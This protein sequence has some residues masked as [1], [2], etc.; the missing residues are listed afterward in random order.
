MNHINFFSCEEVDIIVD[1]S[2]EVLKKYSCAHFEKCPASVGLSVENLWLLNKNRSSR[3][4][5]A[6]LKFGLVWVHFQ[7]PNL[8]IL[9][10][11]TFKSSTN[12]NNVYKGL[13]LALPNVSLILMQ[14]TTSSLYISKTFSVEDVS[15]ILLSTCFQ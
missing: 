6:K 11:P 7:R 4:R 2:G 15:A 1:R 5:F 14:L 12:P 13:A 3:I 9:K 8:K 10:T